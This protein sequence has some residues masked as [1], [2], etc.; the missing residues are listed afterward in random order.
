[1]RAKPKATWRARCW[2]S[3][4]PFVSK[5]DDAEAFLNRGA[6]LLAKGDLEGALLDFNEAIRLKPDYAEAF[7]NRGATS[8]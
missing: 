4:R 6:T 1:M 3:T 7:L 5:P 2:I 8:S